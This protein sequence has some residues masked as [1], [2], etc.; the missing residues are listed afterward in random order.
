M[1]LLD[2]K[3][4]I[5]IMSFL[6]LFETFFM[7]ISAFVSI[8]YGESD[9]QYIFYSSGVTLGF[10]LLGILLT[11]KIKVEMGKR[12]GYLIVALVWIVFSL[13]GLLPFYW[14]G[15]I[16]SFTDAFFE[17]MSGFT[18]TGASILPE[19]EKLSY[20]LLFWRS[21]IQWLG[22]M[23]IIVLSLA[24]LPLLGVG[25]MPLFVA[26]VPGPTKDKLHA[27]ISSTAKI[28]WG[29]YC[30]ITLIQT[31]C[32][33][34]AGMNLFD[35]VCHAF[36]TMATGGFSTK[37]A[38]I[39]Y[40][41]SPLIEYIITFFMF[42]AGINF[43]LYFFLLK[44]NFRKFFHNEE[45]KYYTIFAFVL[46][47]IVF[48]ALTI[49]HS[50]TFGIEERIRYSLFNVISL[51][52]TTGYVNVDYIQWHQ[53]IWLFLLVVMLFGGSAGSTAGGIKTVRI[54]ILIK[55]SYYEFKRLIHP[56]A[57]IPVRFNDEVLKPQLIN[58]VLAFFFLYSV[59]TIVGI[60]FFVACGM[61]LVESIGTAVTAI[62]NVGPGLGIVGPVS[63]FGTIPMACKW[64]ASALML[65][66]RLELFTVLMVFTQ[67]FWKK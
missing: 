59:I 44:G 56:N 22:G 31:L 46:S 25:A 35:S 18:T 58:N 53:F 47:L 17:T 50:E 30:G 65:I 48:V 51:M 20:G 43:S 29:V 23:G 61:G 7:L 10:S 15:S 42:V 2:I 45:F 62:G 16:P 5:R 54:V 33:W 9:Y 34:S 12:E 38:S 49:K 8:A 67:A 3:I 39:A 13:F 36:T 26:E 1:K 27:K 55:N 32:L 21:L 14:S 52:S 64:C 19:V 66:G 24:L 11:P 57:V 41:N 60:L 6:L 4:V 40:W 37:N 63:N 28:L